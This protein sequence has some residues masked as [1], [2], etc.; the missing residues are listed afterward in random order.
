[1]ILFGFKIAKNYAVDVGLLYLYR[2]LADG[3]SFFELEVNYSRYKGDHNPSFKTQLA[4]CNIM[5]LDFNMYNIHHTKC[6][7]RCVV[8]GR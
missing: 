5:I 6:E 7:E 2:S 4:I 1:M 3:M 8:S